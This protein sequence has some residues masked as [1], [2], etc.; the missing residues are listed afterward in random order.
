MS[1]Q[2]GKVNL[3]ISSCFAGKVQDENFDR[4]K[5]RISQASRVFIGEFMTPP[6]FPVAKIRAK[7]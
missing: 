2:R 6:D 4:G 5:T 7:G 3:E 1:L